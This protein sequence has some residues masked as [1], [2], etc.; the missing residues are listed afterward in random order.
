MSPRRALVV[1][2][3]TRPEPVEHLLDAQAKAHA[4][5]HAVER[6]SGGSN[7]EL[8]GEAR[9]DVLVRQGRSDEALPLLLQN[10][11][12]VARAV[13]DEDL[14]ALVPKEMGR[15]AGQATCQRV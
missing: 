2:R 3:S 5:L 13:R 15:R 8:H 10:T 14:V 9:A 6:W 1:G 4:V 12:R 11:L 7:G